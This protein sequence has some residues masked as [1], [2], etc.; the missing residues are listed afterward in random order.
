MMR[1]WPGSPYP[2][3]ATWDG[4]GV[5]FALF[6]EHATRVELCLFDRADTAEAS[7]VIVLPEA[8]DD[9]WHVYLPDARP[10]TMYGYRVHGPY[11]PEEGH[12]F[13]PAKLLIDP[14]AKAVTDNITWSDD[15]FGY[16]IGD[17]HADLSRDDRDSAGAMPKCVVIDQ[18]FSWGD[19]QR[20][21]TPWHRTV[22][23]ECHVKAMTMRHPQVPDELRGTYLGMAYDPVIDHLTNLG[24]T[25]V[26]LMPVH[27]FLSERDLI[28]KG[29]TN[30]W[31]YNSIGFLA[32]H[33]GYAT[34][35]GAGQQ[36]NE[37]K[38][39]VKTLHRAGLEVILDVVYNHTAEGSQLGPTLSLRGID[40][41]AYYRLTPDDRRYMLDFTGTGNSLNLVH[42][43]TMGLIMDSL[44]YWVT[45]MHVD[46]FRFDL[47]PVLAR[48]DEDGAPSAFFEIV[49]QDPILSTVKLIAEPWDVGPDGYQLGKFPQGW[50][51]WNGQYRDSIRK[52][53][54]GDAG[55]VPE[56]ASRLAGS[57]DIFAPSRRPTYASVN[58]VTCHDGFTLTDLVTY[59]DRHNEANG[60]ENKD[61]T[62]ENFSSN[63]GVEGE[64]ESVGIKD[65]RERMKRNLLAT[66]MFSQGVR[67]ILGGDEIG[68]SQFGNN[69]AYCQDNE[70]S[71]LNWEIDEPAQALF[72][73]TRELIA[74]LKRYPALRR[75]H[76]F[77]GSE[78]GTNGDPDVVWIRPDGQEMTEAQWGD[79]QNRTLAMLMPGRAGDEVDDR[80]RALV[81]ETLFW[82]LNAGPSPRKYTLPKLERPGVWEELFSTARP[83]RRV[84][85]T[86]AVNLAGHS[87][88]LLRHDENP[89]A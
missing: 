42:P 17:P 61:G 70:T 85:R 66:V 27:Q 86:A 64:T 82:L 50:S 22:I 49:K 52:F 68:R 45:D 31:G 47:A 51:E 73:F 83:G 43:R 23:Y 84:V 15:L 1:T 39:M 55:M 59:A 65:L 35:G 79:Q 81:G 18:S 36:V 75:R 28:D 62:A 40:N 46:G 71:Y 57:S 14:Y 54:R 26:E 58:F 89:V 74:I 4:E 53:W 19:D 87:T 32:P 77:A 13:N 3:G 29:L 10:G 24:V 2:L 44:R 33:V 16:T 12:R 78:G 69:N 34:A 63:W 72:D 48:G 20:P 60:E 25:A 30:F 5:N 67:M 38:S 9:V 11:E 6:S 88:M 80:G 8:T 41:A 76:F 7:E 37:F 56:V 21:R